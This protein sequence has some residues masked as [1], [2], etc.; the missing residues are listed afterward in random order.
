MRKLLI[1]AM[2]M[3]IAMPIYAQDGD[4]SQSDETT[5]SA[6]AEELQQAID[7]L[8]LEATST[9][10]DAPQGVNILFMLA[11]AAGILGVGMA[12]IGRSRAES[13]RS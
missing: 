12:M 4:D 3:L 9:T 2:F 11:G 6:E 5:I 10:S 8:T 1:L 7:A 13:A